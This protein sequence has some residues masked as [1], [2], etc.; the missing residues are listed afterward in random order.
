M[1]FRILELGRSHRV[2]GEKSG[3]LRGKSWPMANV[4]RLHDR[5]CTVA[6]S[7]SGSFS[8]PKR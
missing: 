8:S 6:K 1:Y 5:V 2:D 3:H 4:A 7:D